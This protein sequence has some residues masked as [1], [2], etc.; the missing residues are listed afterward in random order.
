MSAPASAPRRP[1]AALILVFSVLALWAAPWAAPP[2]FAQEQPP[3]PTWELW[4]RQAGQARQAIEAGGG[5]AEMLDR[6]RGEIEAQRQAALS[7]SAA[8]EAEAQRVQAE[9]DA[10]G[11][12]PEPGP[13]APEAAQLR[14]ELTTALADA[15]ALK[16]RADRVVA[17]AR[18]L[19]AD[20]VELDQQRFVN[21]LLERGPSPVFPSSWAAAAALIG[22][23]VERLGEEAG[24]T[25]SSPMMRAMAGDEA[26]AALIA[27]GAAL[28]VGF[29]LR[30]VVVG[31]LARR[32]AAAG[33]SG[34]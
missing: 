17:R 23:T 26:P 19:R 29:W 10:L 30:N 34:R 2:S 12:P 8:A 5:D 14:D 13:E 27:L 4:D 32:S 33:R 20:L 28:L 7:Q 24:A 18:E 31:A 3:A 9:L 6:I 15:L 16:G 25:F 21:R 22:E 11:P 1:L